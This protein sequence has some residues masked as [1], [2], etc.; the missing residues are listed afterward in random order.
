MTPYSREGK[1]LEQAL[2]KGTTTV[3]LVVS[4]GVV[5]AADKRA[6]TGYFIA[7]KHAKKILKLTD[8]MAITISGVVADA[9]AIADTLR[10]YIKYYQL[11]AKRPLKVRGVASIASTIIFASRAFPILV[12][13]IIAGY[14]DAPRIY[15][16]D[17]F[18]T[19]TEEKSFVTG[20]GSPI[21]SGVI[22]AEYRED[23]S[24]EEAVRLAVKAVS[25]ALKRDAASGEGIDVVKITSKKYEE[26]PK[27]E[28]DKI[29]HSL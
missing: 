25:S 21:A 8:R 6:T 3:G 10:G 7:H 29:L 9:Q 1:Y 20:S 23:L 11:T 16:V 15:S 18:G 2:K 17:W 22:E 24:L 4:E 19:I 14:D 13:L 12:Q 27:D 5:L 28:I 26:L